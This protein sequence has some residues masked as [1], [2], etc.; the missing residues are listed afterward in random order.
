MFNM[1]Q[2]IK[3]DYHATTLD[4]QVIDA[5]ASVLTTGKTNIDN[6]NGSYYK[7]ITI[8]S[9]YKP[10]SGTTKLIIFFSFIFF[11]KNI[12]TN[13]ELKLFTDNINAPLKTIEIKTFSGNQTKEM[14]KMFVIENTTTLSGWTTNKNINIRFTDKSS[15][16]GNI[17]LFSENGNDEYASISLQALG[18]QNYTYGSSINS[19]PIG[20]T[21]PSTGKFTT[22]ENTGVMTLSNHIIPSSNAAFDLGNAEY[23]IRHLFLSDNSLW[24][25]D[26]HK[27]SMDD[28]KL[29]IKTRSTIPA[30]FNGQY[31]SSIMKSIK[32]LNANDNL[33]VNNITL[34]DWIKYANQINQ[35]NINNPDDLFSH[36]ND[37]VPK[38]I[39]SS[40]LN[41]EDKISALE[42]QITNLINLNSLIT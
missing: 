4:N 8:F 30:S 39:V 33:E 27:L 7:D 41:L 16:Q 1:V 17:D 37:F 9:G 13:L 11:D 5:K 42:T 29:T 38:N 24:I 19:L 3:Q 25:G 21:N 23:K 34:N 40:N 35:T 18:S 31:D 26:K 36:V 10:P 12:S 32:G 14:T 15:T 20:D 28:D 2:T 6:S 22:L